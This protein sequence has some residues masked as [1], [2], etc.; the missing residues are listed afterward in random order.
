M[1]RCFTTYTLYRLPVLGER[2]SIDKVL[3]TYTATIGRYT[4]MVEGSDEK[5]QLL[6]TV[7]P[8][9]LTGRRI[10]VRL[11]LFPNLFVVIHH[12]LCVHVCRVHDC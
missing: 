7:V 8:L 2:G 10:D 12:C 9:F 4:C 1:E 3:E 5:H 6:I 11:T